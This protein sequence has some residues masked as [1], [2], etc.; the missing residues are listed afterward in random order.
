V[1][2]PSGQRLLGGWLEERARTGRGPLPG[3]RPRR[4]FRADAVF[5]NL[6]V[7]ELLESE[8][9]KYA[10]AGPPTVCC[11]TVSATCS[12]TLLVASAHGPTYFASFSYQAKAGR[13]IAVVAKVE[14][15]PGELYTR[16]GFIVTN[17][18]R[19]EERVVA[20]HDKRGTCEQWS[21]EGKNA[22]K[23]TRLS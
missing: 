10:P 14:W 18:S 15:H 23:W 7:Y 12:S 16:V 3:A 5:A 21:K 9:Y 17:L 8:R 4:Y 6:D 2:V 1:R 13:R 19:P 20:S 22:I 11:R